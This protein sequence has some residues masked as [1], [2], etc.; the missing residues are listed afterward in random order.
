MVREAAG[1]DEPGG[2]GVSLE[3]FAFAVVVIVIV[4]V[5]VAVG[6]L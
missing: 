2:F 6:E 3:P 4:A 5:V 1:L